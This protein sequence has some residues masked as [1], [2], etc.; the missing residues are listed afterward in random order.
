MKRRLLPLI[1]GIILSLAAARAYAAAGENIAAVVNDAVITVTDIKE[2]TDL[3]LSGSNQAPPPPEERKKVE[4]QVLGKLI[5][6]ALQLQ[7]AKKLDITVDEAQVNSGFEFVAKQNNLTAEAFK[8]RLKDSGVNIDSLYAQIKAEIAWDQ[9]VRRKLRPQVNI[10]ESEIDMTMDQLAHGSGKKQYH[11]AEIFLNVPTA[12]DENDARIKAEEAIDKIKGGATFSSVARA[13]SQSPGAASGGDLGWV[14][15]GQLE[16]ALDKVLATMQPGQITQAIR[17]GQGYHIL[18]LREV[19]RSGDDPVAQAAAGPAAQ[20]PIVTLKQILIPVQPKDPV[21][22]IK[23]KMARGIALKKEI[24]NCDDMDKKM[25]DFAGPGTGPLGTGPQSSLQ[26]ALRVIVEKL[27]VNELSDPVQAPGGWALIM[28]CSR[29]EPTPPP[30]AASA[31]AA[32][33]NSSLGLDKNNE[34]SR[35]NVADKIGAQRLDKMA[36]HYLRDLR[37]SAF[38]DK[39]I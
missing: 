15:E 32:P 3:Y 29:V 13:S 10:S 30:A 22:V 27:S 9:V 12:A 25:K 6:E 1:V 2:R 18:F 17:S 38:I 31:A 34:A 35:E 21:G 36:D 11:V 24:R 19:R 14:Q 20:G 16:P 33:A 23:A 4:Q 39:R 8:K 37:A 5:D 7:E 28:V 26:D